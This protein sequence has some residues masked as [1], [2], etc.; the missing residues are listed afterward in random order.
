[1]KKFLIILVLLLLISPVFAKT[2]QC[3]KKYQTHGGFGTAY[4]VTP[5]IQSMIDEGWKVV[6]ITPVS[7]ARKSSYT[8]ARKS[9][10]TNPTEYI[11][12]IFEKEE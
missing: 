9:S 11:I 4:D 10:Y 5:S 6:S 1:M 12:V 3:V 7:A 2:T 8:A